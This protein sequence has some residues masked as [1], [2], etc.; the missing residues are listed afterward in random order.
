MSKVD[1]PDGIIWVCGRI[2]RAGG[3]GEDI[4][5]EFCDSEKA[6]CRGDLGKD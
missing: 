1:G 5:F 4:G 6:G 3:H 2:P